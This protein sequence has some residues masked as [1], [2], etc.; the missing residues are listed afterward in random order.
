MVGPTSSFAPTMTF[1]TLSMTFINGMSYHNN[2][3]GSFCCKNTFS[4]MF[5]NLFSTLWNCWF[6]IYQNLTNLIWDVPLHISLLLLYLHLSPPLKQAF[7]H[8]FLLLH[9]FHQ[10]QESCHVLKMPTPFCLNLLGPLEPFLLQPQLVHPQLFLK[11][12]EV[13]VSHGLAFQQ[14]HVLVMTPHHHI[15][16]W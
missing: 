10:A 13:V 11:E 6:F 4:H 15:V 9:G 14:V 2:L 12:M 5:N 1:L 16:V 3:L 7:L 8:H